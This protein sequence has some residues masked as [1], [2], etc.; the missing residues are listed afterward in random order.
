MQD[1]VNPKRGGYSWNITMK[2]LRDYSSLIH[3]LES[4]YITLP[5]LIATGAF[6]AAEFAFSCAPTS[7]G[8]VV[9]CI[10]NRTPYR[11]LIHIWN[12]G[13]AKWVIEENKRAPSKF[14][15][16]NNILFSDG[17]FWFPDQ[18]GLGLYD[19]VART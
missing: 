15:G 13:A 18:D 17:Y 14:Y 12:V 7:K 6:G 16:N 10:S 2:A 8:C 9:C 19:P 5:S 4:T 3:L 11:F 1:F